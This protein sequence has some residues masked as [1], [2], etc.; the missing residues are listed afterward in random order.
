MIKIYIQNNE[1]FKSKKFWEDLLDKL[2]KENEQHSNMK[3][4]IFENI[5]TLINNMFEFSLSENEI[6]FLFLI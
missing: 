3:E 5:Y 4:N 6:N 1:S 2:I